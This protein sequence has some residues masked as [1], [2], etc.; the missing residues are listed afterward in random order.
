MGCAR[1]GSWLVIIAFLVA[2]YFATSYALTTLKINTDTGDML[3]SSLGFQTRAKELNEAFPGLKYGLKVIVKTD[4]AD[5][6]DDFTRKLT[7]VLTTD[8][9]NFTD[10]YS[11]PADP[12]LRQ[13]GLLFLETDRLEKRLSKLTKSSQFIESLAS[14]PTATTFFEKL[15]DYESSIDENELGETTLQNVY[16]ELLNVAQAAERGDAQ[17]FSWLNIIDDETDASGDDYQLR[18]VSIMPVLEEGKVHPASE[19]IAAIE[20]EIAILNTA[21]DGRVETWITGGPALRGEELRSV[22]RGIGVSLALSVF[23]VSLLLFLAFRSFYLTALSLLSLTLSILFT[24]AFAAFTVGEFNLVSIAFTVLLVGLGLDFAIHFLLHV[25][26]RRDAGQST[27]M[28]IDGSVHEVGPAL[29]IAAPTTA[30]AFF[31]FLPTNFKGIADLG[32]IAGGGVLIS[33]LV[34]ITFLPAALAAL[35]KLKARKSSGYVRRGFK[36]IDKIAI[37]M[38]LL[39]LVFV[40]YVVRFLPDVRLDSDPMALRDP[41]SPS[42]QGF[43]VLLQDADITPYVISRLLPSQSGA[44]SAADEFEQLSLVS[45]A[46]S[47]L[48]FV[49]DD[50]DEKLELID[51]ASSSLFFALN[52]TPIVSS[53]SNGRQSIQSFAEILATKE[54]GND[55]RQSL[56]DSLSAMLSSQDPSQLIAFEQAIFFY[57]PEFLTLLRDQLKAD[58]ISIDDVPTG[59]RDQYVSANGQWRID[60]SPAEDLSDDAAIRRFIN[61][62]EAVS[63]DIAGGL[64]QSMKAGD[65][66][67]K[68]MLIATASALFVILMVL[69]LLLRRISHVVLILVPLMLAMV[70]TISTGVY[71]NIPFNFA[72]VIVLPLLIGIGVDSGIHLV[73]RQQQVAAGEGLYG[74]S[75]PRAVLVSA[76]TTIA[77]FG[78]LIILDHRGLSSLG[79]MLTIAMLYTMLCMLIVLPA[80]LK[81]T[82]MRARIENLE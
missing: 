42:V 43:N 18:I 68:A 28:A 47:L 39:T 3:A 56:A 69:M 2:G 4:S 21:Y 1:Q 76:L 17:P 36:L 7:A 51:I 59:I 81:L 55:V 29:A 45:D 9:D 66:V 10:I 79:A 13:N 30:L 61:A 35:P 41:E 15:S 46:R 57:W 70:L 14:S 74:T 33:F 19:A 63:P 20:K 22:I 75:T 26:E 78:S 71:L 31:S 6:A 16:R 80:M 23:F 38:A 25:E 77:S 54:K 27:R 24:T 73:M 58:F 49:P 52:T 44:T 12:F 82:G 40:I 34:S 48:D 37:P 53:G 11:P 50:Q 67:G 60:I 65:E 32:L 62:V 64:V 72:N 8:S 5:E